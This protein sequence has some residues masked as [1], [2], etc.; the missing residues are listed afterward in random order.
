[1]GMPEML[2]ILMENSEEQLARQ[3]QYILQQLE[4]EQSEELMSDD[5]EDY[6][7]AEEDDEYETEQEEEIDEEI[8]NA[9]LLTGEELL[10]NE[11]VASM[12]EGLS[13]TKEV[14]ERM[15]EHTQHISRVGHSDLD[16]SRSQISEK[17]LFRPSTPI[18][19]IPSIPATGRNVPSALKSR[20]RIPRTPLNPERLSAVHKENREVFIIYIYIYNCRF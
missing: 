7:E 15:V 3:I 4:N 18:S 14:T 17:I 11:F 12:E 6:L 2:Q 8:A 20:P 10:M 5:T 9:D 1:M 16:E 13:Q 19:M